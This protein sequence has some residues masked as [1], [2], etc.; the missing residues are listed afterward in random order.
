[1]RFFT[2]IGFL[3]LL[4]WAGTTITASAQTTPKAPALLNGQPLISRPKVAAASQQPRYHRSNRSSRLDGD[5]QRLYATWSG[6]DSKI[7]TPKAP[8]EQVLRAAYPQLQLT[9]GATAVLVRITASDVDALLPAL[10]AR[11]FVLQGSRPDLHFMEG[12]LPI[13]QL[14]PG[15][16]GLSSLARQGLMGVLPAYRP[17][18]NGGLQTSQADNVLQTDRL[19]NT[20]PNLYNGTGVRIGVMS[21]SYNSLR[22]AANDVASGD[23]PANIQV[24]QDFTGENDGQGTDEGRGMMQLIYDLAPNSPLAFSS[25]NFGEINFAA[26][27][28]ALA[29]PAVGNCK[30]LTDDIRYYTEPF[31]QDGVIAQAITEVVNQRGV[32][33]FSSAGN[34]ADQSY[35]NAAPAFVAVGTEGDAQ[36]NFNATGATPDY[37]QSFTIEQGDDVLLALQWADPFYTTVGVKT[38][39]DLF[40]LSAKGDT[41]AVGG[42]DNI[43]TQMPYEILSFAND[44]SIT[45]TTEFNLI[46]SRYRGTANTT[47]VKYVNY[48]SALP[49][50][51]D[52]RS[53]TIVG[54]AATTLA[55]AVAAV[56]YF[57]QRQA[58]TFT[59]RGTPT[60]LFNPNGTPLP[61][62]VTRPKPDIASVD[63]TNTT[64]FAPFGIAAADLEGDGF[65]N[66]FGT[67]AA[68][69]HAAAVAALLRQAEPNLTPAQV[70][71]RLQTTA[72]DLGAPGYDNITG[73]GLIDAFRAVYGPVTA[74][75]LP[76][77]QDFETQALPISWLINND[78][79]G[80]VEVRTDQGPASGKAHMI[81]SAAVGVLPTTDNPRGFLSSSEAILYTKATNLSGNLLL[82]FREK[83]FANETDQILPASFFGSANGDG[84]S[85][86]VDGGNKWYRLVNLTGTASTTAYQTFSYNLTQFAQ[87]N[88][89]TL[90]DDVRIKFQQY[91]AGRPES[92]VSGL[93]GGIAFD[94]IALTASNSAPVPL[95]TS[96]QPTTGCPGLS[97]TYT[98]TS[99]LN[100]TSLSW[101]FPG[102]TPATSTAANPVVTYAAGGRFAVMLTAA[103]A[104][105]TA[106]RTDTG[107]VVVSGRAP[108]VAVSASRTA[109]CPGTSITFTSTTA[110]C[111]GTYAWTFPGGSPA[112]SADPNPTVTYAN[113]GTYTATLIVSNTYGTTTVTQPVEVT[114]GQA[115]PFAET[116]DATP[117]LPLGWIINNP[118]GTFTWTLVDNVVNRSGTASR[119]IQAPFYASTDT[120]DDVLQTP[121]INLSGATNLL[122][123]LAYAPISDAYPDSL[124][125]QVV[126]ACSLTVLGTVYGKGQ[127]QLAT[128]A[129]QQNYFTP[130]QAADWRQETVDLSAYAGQAVLLRFVARSSNG[131]NLY[132]DNVQ[133]NAQVLATANSQ[134]A[135]QVQT[136][137]NPVHQGESFTLALPA[138]R[139]A[140]ALKLVDA[141][142]RVVWQQTLTLPNAPTQH[143]VRVPFAAG[144]YHL[145]YQPAGGTSVVRR[146]L[147]Y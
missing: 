97:V 55:Q 84:V 64:T 2:R 103:N 128:V 83:E 45:H 19:R 65:P 10:R 8:T 87:T 78:L 33:Y 44:T 139:G 144:V 32:T 112:T 62:P 42:N 48:G 31:F 104:N 35:E 130:K 17:L 101:S 100:P 140:A 24:L 107:Y 124:V 11:G 77:V 36:L 38:D 89:L 95:F 68:A 142:G 26:Q 72:H 79:A 25:V 74:T 116:F 52:T 85:L 29:D 40:L 111:P 90:G 14:D 115:L 119:V 133:V 9:K 13:S 146:V 120:T 51:W 46:I 147:V 28:K 131:N 15:T 7:K 127:A 49:T 60:F 141:V 82:T 135:S 41:V 21:D 102:G 109:V 63:G 80:R 126:D 6:A 125:I 59:S 105:G 5:L 54:H 143:T 1:M 3:G 117:T 43:K 58:E 123:D 81:L 113:A 121:A 37:T 34:N 129:A 92:P 99:L 106:A 96:S 12:L 86:S 30:V 53:G 94:D 69:P 73:F 114:T 61:A 145:L 50:E 27:I 47:R 67:S 71:S 23:L 76:T 93:T 57:R 134:V 56:P 16:K 138:Q 118:D 91:G 20:R 98:S 122:F 66:F 75:T 137:P 132:L 136:W 18:T 39:L 110:Y 70:Y 88:N 4:A 22:G 108:Q